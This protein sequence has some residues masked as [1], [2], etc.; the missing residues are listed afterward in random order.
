MHPELALAIVAILSWTSATFFTN[1]V[2]TVAD[3]LM[4]HS[5]SKAIVY[6]TFSL[7]FLLITVWISIKYK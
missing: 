3:N 2:G 5:H 6:F 4:Q 7:I 1:G